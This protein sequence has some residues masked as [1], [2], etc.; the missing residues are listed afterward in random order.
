MTEEK[1][2]VILNGYST[3]KGEYYV[4][5]DFAKLFNITNEKAKELF[6]SAPVT[7]KEGLSSEQANQYRKSVEKVG[8]K[9][10]V[11]SMRFNFSGLSLE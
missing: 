6:N 7:L 1:Y 10:E 11:E 5:C 9:C 3:G 8:A 2:R 4:E